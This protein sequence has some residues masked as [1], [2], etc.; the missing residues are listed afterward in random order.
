MGLL[1]GWD[2]RYISRFLQSRN[3][4]LRENDVARPWSC[5]YGKRS[6]LYLRII[7]GHLVVE[8]E[9]RSWPTETVTLAMPDGHCNQA[10][11]KGIEAL[12]IPRP[13]HAQ[14]CD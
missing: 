9:K 7:V 10:D 6:R 4:C 11:G 13:G 14:L 3:S 8:F 12:W 5:Q 2:D 1:P